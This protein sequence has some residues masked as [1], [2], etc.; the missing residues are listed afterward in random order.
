MDRIRRRR[1]LGTG[2]GWRLSSVVASVG[3]GEAMA[4]VGG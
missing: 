2:A 3:G 1:G 4:V